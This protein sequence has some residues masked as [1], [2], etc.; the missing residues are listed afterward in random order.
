MNLSENESL[1]LT[2][3]YQ[4][5][6]AIL[7]SVQEVLAYHANIFEERYGKDSELTVDLRVLSDAFGQLCGKDLESFSTYIEGIKAQADALRDTERLSLS[8]AELAHMEAFIH[9]SQID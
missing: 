5:K 6:D 1:P 8:P 7:R 2:A 4:V 3:V 9:G